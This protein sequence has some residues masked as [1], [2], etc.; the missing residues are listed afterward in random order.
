MEV[1][2]HVYWSGEDEADYGVFRG[3][4][5]RGKGQDVWEAQEGKNKTS[6]TAQAAKDKTSS[7]AQSAND[8]KDQ[9]G[10]YLSEKAQI[11]KEKAAKAAK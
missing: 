1:I 10:S 9:T 11:A 6:E 3:K 5:R 7:T 8:T 2:L 4:G